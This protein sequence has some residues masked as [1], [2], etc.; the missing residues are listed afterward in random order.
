M[1]FLSTCTFMGV[2]Y[3]QEGHLCVVVVVVVAMPHSIALYCIENLFL[4]LKQLIVLAESLSSSET[5]L[6]IPLLHLGSIC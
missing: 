3:P 6:T 2:P 4:R 5:S 1:Y